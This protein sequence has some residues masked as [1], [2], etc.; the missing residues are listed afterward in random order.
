M[1]SIVTHKKFCLGTIAVFMF[2]IIL[3]LVVNKSIYGFDNYLFDNFIEELRN[4]P[5]TIIMIVISYAS[6]AAT[7]ITICLV[8]FLLFKDKKIP[9]LMTLNLTCVTL[10]NQ[11]TKRIIQR[12]RP[13]FIIITESGFSFPS[14]HSMA[15]TAFYGYIMYL[16]YKN[17]KT[18]WK[19]I[20]L[21][22][23]LF[24]L[25]IAICFS[26]MYLGAHFFSDVLG[27]FMLSTCYL[28]LFITYSPKLYEE[29][30][31]K[32]EEIWRKRR[33]K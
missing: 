33:K 29:L 30:D 18:L 7:F 8:S 32:K 12:P 27:G 9:T 15:S 16:V 11:I 25:I 6:S 22:S 31:K 28:M 17:V 10:V 5:L 3:F 2:I 21:C 4:D 13:E 14:G 24:I 20:L 23:L 1:K 26:R 19:K